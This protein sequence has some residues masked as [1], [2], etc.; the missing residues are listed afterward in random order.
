MSKNSKKEIKCE[1][2]YKKKKKRKR[3][4]IRGN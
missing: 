3:R 1:R 2:V 4:V